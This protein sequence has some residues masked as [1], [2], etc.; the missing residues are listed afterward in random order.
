MIKWAVAFLLAFIVTWL[1]ATGYWAGSVNV[2][3]TVF[4]IDMT[5]RFIVSGAAGVIVGTWLG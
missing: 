5:G 4:G 3:V 1:A 2:L